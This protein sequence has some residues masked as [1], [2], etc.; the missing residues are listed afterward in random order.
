[1]KIAILAATALSL[2]ILGTTASAGDRGYSN[3]HKSY[4]NHYKQRHHYKHRNRHSRHHRYNYRRHSSN[5]GYILGGLVL[6]GL[7][8][9]AYHNNTYHH[10][11]TV[12]HT[13]KVIRPPETV[14]HHTYEYEKT[15]DKQNGSEVLPSVQLLKDTQGRCFAIT[16]N[17]E[18]EQVLSEIEQSICEA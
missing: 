1:M 15:E 12:V 10:P 13:T 3:K 17:D 6:G 7:I 18:G 16:H 4:K 14:V 9:H 8:N 2:A 11:S 5:G